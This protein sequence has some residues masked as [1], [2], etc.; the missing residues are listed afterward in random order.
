MHFITF[1]GNFNR[2]D[3]GLF[4]L[5]VIHAIIYLFFLSVSQK[6]N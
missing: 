1:N 6:T 3:Y 4:K 2:K 5:K